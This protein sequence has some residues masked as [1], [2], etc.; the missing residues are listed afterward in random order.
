MLD[1]AYDSSASEFEP[2]T[3]SIEVRDVP[4]VLN[5]VTGVCHT[6][7]Y[8]NPLHCGRLS[9]HKACSSLV[10]CKHIYPPS[11]GCNRR[12]LMIAALGSFP[13][14]MVVRMEVFTSGMELQSSV[15]GVPRLEIHMAPKSPRKVEK[16]RN[17]QFAI[18]SETF[19]F[20]IPACPNSKFRL[21]RPI[22]T[23]R[24]TSSSTIC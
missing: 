6:A 3:I 24:P 9:Y 19:G 12:L 18:C 5:Q 17:L 15:W 16:S 2:H 13:K 7:V 8:S 1:A 11:P 4:G 22:C 20:K 21:M 23:I 14:C 10:T